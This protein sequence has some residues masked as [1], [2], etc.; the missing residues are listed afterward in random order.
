MYILDI[1]NLLSLNVFVYIVM[2]LLL[3]VVDQ[4]DKLVHVVPM[5]IFGF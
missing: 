4:N 1:F 3:K 5:M 2:Y